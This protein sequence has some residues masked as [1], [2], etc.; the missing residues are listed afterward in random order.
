[1]GPTCA[2]AG[3]L[4]GVGKAAMSHAQQG[5]AFTVEQV[6]LDEARPRRH[7]VVPLPAEAVG[8]PMNRHDLAKGPA[9]HAP[10]FADAFHEIKTV[11]MGL[12]LRLGAQPT[13]DLFGIGKEGEDGGGGCSDLNLAPDDKRLGHREDA[14]GTRQKLHKLRQTAWAGT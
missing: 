13:D 3:A 5:T 9:R 1:M 12:G 8:E 6:D 14:K 2:M 10:P 7:L 11:G 4:S